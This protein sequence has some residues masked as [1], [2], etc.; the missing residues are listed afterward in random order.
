MESTAVTTM[1][2]EGC[3]EHGHHSHNGIPV[4]RN[5]MTDALDCG[6]LWTSQSQSR[7]E[8]GRSH[9]GSHYLTSL[10]SVR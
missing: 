3:K 7:K 10:N 2:M 9:C 1:R 8:V 6:S 4:L 5:N